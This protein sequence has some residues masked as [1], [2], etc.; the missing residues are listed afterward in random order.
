[1][2][3]FIAKFEPF[4]ITLIILA[5]IWLLLGAPFV[6]AQT[7]TFQQELRV[8]WTLPNTGCDARTNPPTCGALTPAN[9][10]TGVALFFS[11]SPIPD[12]TSTPTITVPV[13]QA[14]A[15]HTLSVAIGETVYVRGAAVNVN[16][17]GG[18][19]VQ[20]SYPVIA[21]QVPGVLI[22]TLEIPSS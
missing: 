3:K 18:L 16:G 17:A 12:S 6:N 7:Q 20:K 5:V 2:W 10:V 4:F 13:S 9:A 14:S 21:R 19:S 15:A 8:V 11:K 22:L 1:M